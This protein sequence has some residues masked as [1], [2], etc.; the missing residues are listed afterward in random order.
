MRSI[1]IFLCVISSFLVT[2]C[3]FVDYLTP[4]GNQASLKAFFDS[5]ED[6]VLAL[7]QLDSI[8]QKRGE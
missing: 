8:I 7:T 6:A 3:V 5:E 4:N 1:W 2:S